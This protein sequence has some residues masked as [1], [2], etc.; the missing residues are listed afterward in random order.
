[1][2]EIALHLLDIAENSV[3]AGG[4]TIRVEVCEDLPKDELQICVTDDGKGMDKQTAQNALDPFH[5]ARTTRK[6]GLGLPLLKEAAE[7]AGGGLS[8]ETELGKGAKVE[9]R[10]QH[11]HI[12][13]APLGDLG[14]TFLALLVSHPSVHWIFVY[15]V[16][17]ADGAIRRFELDDEEI[18]ATL[19][20]VSLTEPQVLKILRDIIEAGV[21]AP[22]PQVIC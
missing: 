5:T 3:A 18:K 21:K 1:M 19:E 7:S 20:G 13:R 16:A 22:A 12:D 8:L 17:A 2:R 6:V 9:A 15:Q 14:A 10:F 4:R 11:S